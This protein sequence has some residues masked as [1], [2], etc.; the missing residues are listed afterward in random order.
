MIGRILPRHVVSHGEFGDVEDPFLHPEEEALVRNAVATRRREF[1]TGRHCARQALA[2]LGLPAQG[3]LLWG[4][5]GS[6]RWPDSV[7]GS[8]THCAGYRAAA[9]AR[10]AEVASV[11]I[12]AEPDQPL[13]EGILEAVALPAE[14]ARTAELLRDAP[15]VHWDRMLFSAKESVYKVWYPL[16]RHPLGF[17][18]A[19]IRIEPATGTFSA[20]LL[21][22]AVRG[23]PREFTG[24]WVA[25][26]GLLATAITLP[27][28]A[29]D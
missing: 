1:A 27:A 7:R 5:K 15:G 6:V 2:A 13:P 24:R 9:V 14:R 4:D 16:T 22:H 26:N 25:A 19:L 11:G 12:D 28:D 17:E 20:R 10:S 18:D 3:P 29:L 8:I 21:P 23:V